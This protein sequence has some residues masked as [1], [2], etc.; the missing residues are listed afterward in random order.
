MVSLDQPFTGVICWNGPS[1]LGKTWCHLV[2]SPSFCNTNPLLLPVPHSSFN[3][4]STNR[5]LTSTIR[6]FASINLIPNPMTDD[7][8]LHCVG[9]LLPSNPDLVGEFMLM[10]WVCYGLLL[11]PATTFPLDHTMRSYAT[12]NH[13][14]NPLHCT[15][16]S[17][18]HALH[19]DTQI[20]TIDIW[21]HK[22]M[23]PYLATGGAI[24]MYGSSVVQGVTILCQTWDDL[25]WASHPRHEKFVHQIW[26]PSKKMCIYLSTEN[27]TSAR[28][29]TI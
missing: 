29:R 24:L 19:N 2:Q 14:T 6:S 15:V 25:T 1:L 28:L 16:T 22:N 9:P 20:D 18:K 3:K 17:N 7:S 5:Q 10:D 13:T 26:R 11:D 8:A 23:T 27:H 12:I 4:A 21:N